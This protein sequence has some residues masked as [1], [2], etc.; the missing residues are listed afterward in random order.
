[1]NLLIFGPQGCG[2]G[3]QA[4]LL[5]R[6]YNLEHVETGYIFRQIAKEDTPLGKTIAELNEKKEM[7]P[8]DIVVEV[9][10]DKL[11]RISPEK[12]LILDSAP[13][14]VSQIDIIEK[15]LEHIGR[16][17]DKA[18]SITLSREESIARINKRYSCRLCRRHFVLGENIDSANKP[19]P[20]CGGPIAQRLDDTP[21]G[22]IKR[23]DTFQKL[24]VPVIEYYRKKGMLIEVD[25]NQ[26][27]EKVFENITAKL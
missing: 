1:M 27:I 10:E 9:L 22:V 26:N 19:C 4:D 23:L 18:I 3:T 2:K 15:M 7:I 20:T 16:T 25:G 21:D 8:D 14:V 6:K 11:K 24:T 12:G 13:R 5:A 17:V